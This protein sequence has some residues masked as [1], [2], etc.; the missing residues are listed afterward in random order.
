LKR[1]SYNLIAQNRNFRQFN[2]GGFLSPK[3]IYRGSSRV[4]K[5]RFHKEAIRKSENGLPK[6][7]QIPEVETGFD[8]LT[9]AA[10]RPDRCLLLARDW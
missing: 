4:H 2:K 8:N 5:T 7:D 3:T 6:N 1:N 10:H 9:Q